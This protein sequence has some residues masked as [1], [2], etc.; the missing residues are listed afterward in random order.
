M[1]LPIVGLCEL[2]NCPQT[3]GCGVLRGSA[4]PSVG[5]NINLGSFY[6]VGMPVAVFLGF[7]VKMGFAGL[8][9]GLLAAQASCALLMV[10]VLCKTDWVVQVKRA[11]ELTITDNSSSDSTNTDPP[12][13]LPLSS[14]SKVPEADNNFLIHQVNKKGCDLEEVLC[15]KDEVVFKETDPLVCDQHIVHR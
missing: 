9:L 2:G 14:S 3:T 13:L 6:L 8:W 15:V 1:A 11:K 7:V 5:A 10:F 4:R 12:L